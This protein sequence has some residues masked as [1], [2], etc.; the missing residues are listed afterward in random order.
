MVNWDAFRE[1]QSNY[2]I[3][4]TDPNDPMENAEWYGMN[5]Y[6]HCSPE[7]QTVDELLGWSAFRD[8]FAALNHPIPIVVAEY[9]CRE[10]FPEI[11]GFEAQRTWLQVDA[12]YR[13][14]YVDVF[15]G[16]VVF[17][18]S[19]EKLIVEQD[20]TGHPWPYYKFMKVDTFRRSWNLFVLDAEESSS[21]PYLRPCF[22]LFLSL[23]FVH[24][25][26]PSL[27]TVWATTAP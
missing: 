18:F 12:L 7:A 27:I 10:P 24:F 17:E 1:V 15:A 13:Q 23:I 21:N 3:C 19:A 11:D 5:I 20:P 22:S 9:G 6:Q 16:G 4:R 25:H 14:D 8:D 26:A 2:F